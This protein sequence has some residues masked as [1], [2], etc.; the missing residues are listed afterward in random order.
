M[1]TKV[2]FK[3]L[4][5]HVHASIYTALTEDHTYANNGHLVFEVG[6]EWDHW[7]RLFERGGA[8][9]QDTTPPRGVS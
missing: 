7:R 2:R 9:L 4:G 8:V 5:G 6:A 1:V 3:Q